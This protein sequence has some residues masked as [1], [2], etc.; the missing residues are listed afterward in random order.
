MWHNSKFDLCLLCCRAQR[1]Y[2]SAQEALDTRCSLHSGQ[3]G[4]F[5]E[6]RAIFKGRLSPFNKKYLLGTPWSSSVFVHVE[7]FVLETRR[8]KYLSVYLLQAVWNAE[9][10]FVRCSHTQSEILVAIRA[11]PQHAETMDELK[12]LRLDLNDNLNKPWSED[13]TFLRQLSM[14]D[15]TARQKNSFSK[16]SANTAEW[17]LDSLELKSWLESE[18]DEHSIIWCVGDPGVGKTIITSVV[19]DHITEK[20]L[21]EN[22]AIVYIYCDYTNPLTFSVVNLLGS[23]VRQLIVQTTNAQMVSQLKTTLEQAAKSRHLTEEELSVWIKDLSRTF[24]VVYTFVDA[25]DECPEIGRDGLLTWIQQYKLGHMR[26]FLTSRFNVEVTA[27]IPR[28]IKKKVEAT[29]EDITASVESKI[30]R[31]LRLTK[32]TAED[33]HLKQYI[34]ESIVC[35]AEGMFLLAGLQ[36]ESL[37]SQI[38]IRGVRCALE[39][40]PTDLFTMYDQTIER[41]REQSKENAELGLKVLSFMFVAARPLSVGELRHALAIRAGDATLDIESLVDSEILLSVTAGLVTICDGGAYKDDFFEFVHHT[42]QEYLTAEQG[43][44]FPN[45]QFDMARACLSF[46][47]FDVYGAGLCGPAES[48]EVRK[49]RDDFSCYAIFNCFH[50]L[51]GVQIELMDQCLAF[52]QDDAKF[53]AWAESLDLMSGGQGLVEDLI[54]PDPVFFAAHFHLVDLFARLISHRGID[55]INHLGETPLLRAVAVEPW[56]KGGE[57]PYRNFWKPRIWKKGMDPPFLGSV[58]QEQHAMVQAILDRGAD[59]NAKDPLGMTAALR[60]VKNYNGA[61]LYLLLDRGANINAQSNKGESLLHNAARHTSVDFLQFLL[62][63]GA[64]VHVLT[65][66]REG[67]CHFTAS[68]PTSTLLNSLID[69]GAPFDMKNDKGFT[70]LMIAAA[71]G[72]LETSKTLMKHGASLNAIDIKGRTPLHHACY[73]YGRSSFSRRQESKNRAAMA[74]DVIR[75]LIENGASVAIADAHGRTAKRYL[76]WNTLG[77]RDEFESDYEADSKAYLLWHDYYWT[78]GN[79]ED[80]PD[81][82]HA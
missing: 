80:A 63:R 71:R 60:A 13:Q 74:I 33:P 38:S 66:Q 6:Q 9:H 55:V 58:D 15:F 10:E 8:T 59:I 36:I 12:K 61:I 37:S 41:I 34:T 18:D 51:R 64:D 31:N 7:P 30:R 45:S 69:H 23:I 52:L 62:D 56:K 76:R 44:L 20:S 78:F 81:P 24:D 28:V 17:M 46:L 57:R 82:D 3:A 47:S 53:C 14:L 70:P 67:L 21:G 25:L 2:N 32:F 42:L 11:L 48:V 35:Q 68:H 4:S 1:I 40:L 50:H 16:R 54:P 75:Q 73:Q 29:S 22:I 27:W 72:E 77:L 65:K 39:R 79:L 49:H 19:V 26:I 5:H 43:R